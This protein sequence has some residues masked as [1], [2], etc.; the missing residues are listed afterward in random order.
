MGPS[1]VTLTLPDG[2][3]VGE[4]YYIM[5]VSIGGFQ[6]PSTSLAA[7]TQISRTSAPGVSSTST[8]TTAS[9]MANYQTTLCIAMWA[10]THWAIT[11]STLT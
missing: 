7:T 3:E 8:V 6:P 10:D 11:E 2:G 5:C 1:T 4:T 9:G